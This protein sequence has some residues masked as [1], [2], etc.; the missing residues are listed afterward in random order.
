M[1]CPLELLFVFR[2]ASLLGRFLE[3]SVL[4][5]GCQLRFF[6]F[7]HTIL[8]AA[9]RGGR[10]AGPPG[11]DREDRPMA[12]RKGKNPSAPAKDPKYADR[13]NTRRAAAKKKG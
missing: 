2:H 8:V 10:Q 7:G 4:L 1:K 11:S 5:G 6:A 12:K 9:V 13:K 3:A